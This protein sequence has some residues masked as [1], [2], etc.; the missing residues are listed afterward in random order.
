MAEAIEYKEPA[1]QKPVLKEWALTGCEGRKPNV[2]RT[3]FLQQKDALEEKNMELKAKYDLITEELQLSETRF[4]DDAEIAVIAY[5]TPARI[6]HWAVK[7][8]REAG[9]KVGLFRPI[10]L[11]PFPARELRKL[12][13][14]CRKLLVVEMSQ[15][16]LIE[17]VRLARIP[18]TEV[19]PKIEF[20]G[21][22]G[23]WYPKPKE[24]LARILEIAKR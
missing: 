2:I 3:L 1:K 24:L 20:L 14:H 10:T 17:D 5:G 9:V 21:R 16:Q 13:A 6:A 18:A 8:A 11:W 12:A 7:K 15:G 22:G 19:D 23:G 4:G